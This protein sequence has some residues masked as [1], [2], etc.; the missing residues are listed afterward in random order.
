MLSDANGLVA[1]VLVLG[2]VAVRSGERDLPLGGAKQQA[3]LARL[4]VAR[5]RPLAPARL[6]NE[7]WEHDAPSDPTHALQARVS[8]L[9]SAVP[10]KIDLVNGGYCIDPTTFGTDVAQFEKLRTEG[11]WLL[12]DGGLSQASERLDKALE[13]WRGP[14]FSDT[15]DIPAL[16][17]ESARLEKLWFSTLADRIDID[18]AL[19]REAAVIPELAALVKE[20]PLHER[21]VG[22]LMVALYRDGRAQEALDT[23]A[24]ARAVLADTLGVEPSNELGQ[25]HV[26][27]LRG[28]PS[29]SL[30]RL[31][32][33]TPILMASAGPGPREAPG[34]VRITSNETGTLAA[35]LQQHRAL[36]VTGPAGIGKTH[37]LRAVRARLEAQ[38]CSA[39]LLSASELSQS[40]PLGVFAG[41]TG[42]LAEDRATPASLIDAFARHRSTTALL[43]DNVSALDETSLFVVTQLISTSRVPTIVA[44]RSLTA[45]PAAIRDLYDRGDLVEVRVDRL[46]DREAHELATRIVGGSLT[47]DA[48]LRILAAGDGNPFQIREV[49]LGSMAEDR[50]VRTEQ[51]WVLHGDPAPSARLTQRAGERLATLD[52][53]TVE[54]AALVAIA[55]EYPAA[56]LTSE[57]RRSV[58]DTGVVSLTDGG[59]LQLADQLDREVLRS[60]CAQSRWHDLTSEV[61]RV[62]SSELAA[63]VPQAQWRARV[64]ALELGGQLDVAATITL[65]EYALA[66]FDERLALR[67]AEAVIVAEPERVEGH[68]LAGLASSALGMATTADAHFIEARD[69]AT[70]ARELVDVALARAD[71]WGLRRHDAT[72]ALEIVDDAARIVGESDDLLT[73]RLE[74]GRVRWAMVAGLSGEGGPGSELPPE[75]VDVAGLISTGVAS[76]IRGPLADAHWVLVR[77]GSVPAEIISMVPGGAAVVALTE[78]MALS[79]SGD[80]VTAHR[81][82]QDKLAQANTEASESLGMWEYA[83][84]F[85][86]LLSGS[87]ERAH[88]YAVAAVEHL[89]W[90]DPTGSL[91]AA[92]A[93]SA[94]SLEGCGRRAEAQRVLATISETAAYDPKV[95]ML[96]AWA[97]A[98]R[99]RVEGRHDD[100]VST[101]IDTARWL[102]DVQ[103]N[104]FAGML[105]HCAVRTGRR[106]EEAMALIT[107]A[108]EVAGGGLL[109]LFVRHAEACAARDRAGLAQIARHAQE[110]GI[111]TTAADTW[112]ALA[113]ESGSNR[114]GE[115]RE[116]RQAEVDKIR[117]ENPS[118][119]LWTE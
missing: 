79:N 8:R 102:L 87:T 36:V 51:G 98:W 46:D 14:A 42:S 86:E 103:H 101:L 48:R 29:E 80:M 76:V 94:A 1:D 116:R 58:L 57:Q 95:V 4:V 28:A 96:R 47:P 88:D 3:L 67:A 31:P 32:S 73:L 11:G 97:D 17:A 44:A 75:V 93:L 69:R 23:Y 70:S 90:R 68:R 13:L 34:D 40:I 16:D 106:S 117:A 55:G 108:Y 12:A 83:L 41:T 30:L 7:L 49:V 107:E 105:A 65:A 37:L 118:M 111:M 52:Q 74:R 54:A 66:A 110:L 119:V 112:Q 38:H 19:G 100:A 2:P 33:A 15:R 24:R 63:E 56:A 114:G 18:L 82:L 43:V 77:L 64:L 99:A 10:L 53:K 22:Q 89:R 109:A 5:G 71:H 60:R 61:V 35:L 25:L 92:L 59:W 26:Q 72:T 50:L 62:L 113:A 81:L 91:P 20:F 39:P 9:R 78:I 85:T 84:G 21:H 115:L 104:Y 6:C 27:I 45:A